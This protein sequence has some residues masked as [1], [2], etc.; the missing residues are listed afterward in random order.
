MTEITNRAALALLEDIEARRLANEELAAKATDVIEQ[1]VYGNRAEAYQTALRL[2][3]RALPA[4]IE[5][6]D[7][8]PPSRQD[9][10]MAEMDSATWTPGEL[11]EVW[12][13]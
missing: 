6:A 10:G 7:G 12:G 8:T 1:A 4:I 2:V 13:K 9:R 5:E 11:V 3:A